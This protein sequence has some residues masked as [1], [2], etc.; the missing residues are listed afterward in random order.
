MDLHKTAGFIH[1]Q[2]APR[3]ATIREVIFGL[4]DGLVSTLGALTGI[5]AGTSNRF[6]II[7]SGFVIIAVESISMA[8]GSYLSSKSELDIDKRKLTEEEFE[9][10]EYPAEEKTELAGMYVADG[11]SPPLAAEMAEEASKNHKL[12]LQEMAY[13]ELKVFPENLERPMSNALFMGLSYLLGGAI[14][15]IPYLILSVSGAISV[16]VV[17]TLSALFILGALTSRYSKRS[18]WRAG[19]EMFLLA[20]AAALIGYLVGQGVERWWLVGGD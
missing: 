11:W 1:H 17:V 12:F 18:W 2:K 9:L 10:K 14:P 7:L 6:V 8:V 3:S 16:S 5:A 4:E 20:S 13:R 19:L 15:L